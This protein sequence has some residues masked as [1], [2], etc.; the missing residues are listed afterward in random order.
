M[1]KQTFV[2]SLYAQWKLPQHNLGEFQYT[3]VVG[4]LHTEMAL[5]MIVWDLLNGSGWCTALSEPGVANIGTAD[6]FL[7][8]S[9]L[10]QDTSRTC[11]DCH[12]LCKTAT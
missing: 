4:G 12:V 9:I 6:S 10:Y 2:G 1:C 7:K 5:W 11:G 8:S 3:I